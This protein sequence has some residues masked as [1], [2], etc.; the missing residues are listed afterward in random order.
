MKTN[1]A[2][3]CLTGVLLNASTDSNAAA[4]SS[5]FG[6]RVVAKGNGFQ[7]TKGEVNQAVLEYKANLAADGQALP[8]GMN[9][10][11]RVKI[12][13]RIVALRV[14]LGL[15][16]K[17]DRKA[18]LEVAD[19]FIKEAK[20]E[21][22]TDKEYKR[23]LMTRGFTVERWESQ[24]RDKEISNVVLQRLLR[25]KITV[26]DQ[27]VKDYY[28]SHPEEFRKPELLRAAHILLS[29][30]DPRTR[31]LLPEADKTR[32]RRI[33]EKLLERARKGEDFAR[34]A[35]EFSEDPGS[36]EKGGEYVFPRGQMIPEF[37]AAAFAL[38]VGE[39]SDIVET[40]FGYHIIKSL[41]RKPS[42]QVGFADISEELRGGLIQKKFKEALPAFL[43]AEKKVA[44]VEILE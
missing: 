5:L 29:T 1:L 43:E 21:A 30:T 26:S 39:I 9:E 6:D 37:E 19:K 36:K 34:L 2:L 33:A 28:N 3:A 8:P 35:K 17:E 16:S 40:K 11:I 31:R 25:S 12:R 22:K 38:R 7:V 27:E 20:K 14:V 42:S 44:G 18:G 13:D 41:E 24:I 32:K 23:K 15:A 10:G 4:A